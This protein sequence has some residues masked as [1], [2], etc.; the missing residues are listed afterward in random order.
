MAVPTADPERQLAV[1][2]ARRESEAVIAFRA[3]FEPVLEEGFSDMSE[4]LAETQPP[5]CRQPFDDLV[6]HVA[7]ASGEGFIKQLALRKESA[8]DAKPS[9]RPGRRRKGRVT[10]EEHVPS[11]SLSDLFLASAC[12]ARD[13]AACQRLVEIVDTQVGRR[14][15]KQFRNRLSEGRAQEVVDNVLS[16]AWSVTNSHLG[17]PPFDDADDPDA[18][19]KT[20]L[21]LEKYLG[22]STLRTWLFSMAYH[23]LI[24]ETR[25]PGAPPQGEAGEPQ[26]EIRGEDPR[27]ID[28]V[29][30][31]EL[32]ERFRPRLQSDLNRALRELSDRKSERL[33]QVAVLWLPLRA[34]QV[35]IAR[36]YGVT[37]ARVSQQAS[38]ITEYFLSATAATCRD[39]STQSGIAH[40]TIVA[41][42]RSNLPAFFEPLLLQKLLDAFRRLR[43]EQPRLFRLAFLKW[44]QAR[45]LAEMAEQMEESTVRIARLQEQLE[46]WRSR[47]QARIAEELAAQTNVPLEHLNDRVETALD[48]LFGGREISPDLSVIQAS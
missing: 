6:P 23:M 3:T 2:V 41:A 39:L 40:D 16:Q 48:E 19:P 1:R 20:R 10:F 32:V 18:V 12:L 43:D 21:R 42:L 25:G 34:Q 17:T 13:N 44:R 37:K 47:T 28:D 30:F 4:K 33:A 9:A 45:S 27:P 35:Q 31:R 26:T 24:E 15:V 46:L 7:G 38:E 29:A 36:M 5:G 14:L 22:L 11:L 8:G